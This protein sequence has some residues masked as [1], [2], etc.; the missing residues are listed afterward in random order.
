MHFLSIL[1]PG[2]FSW[3]YTIFANF[4]HFG[5]GILL[6]F[7]YLNKILINP[8]LSG[9]KGFWFGLLLAYTGEIFF[10]SNFLKNTGS[11]RFIFESTGPLI[12]TLGFSIMM[13]SSLRH[14]SINK[15]LACRPFVFIGRI[16]FSFYLWHILSIEFSFYY[17]KQFISYSRIGVLILSLL[18]LIFII[19]ISYI[20]F[21]IFESFYF[22]SN[23]SKQN[24]L[25]VSQINN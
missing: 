10:Y 16:S 6:G 2:D 3:Y 9:W 11:L 4:E 18:C 8:F 21:N 14:R 20:S 12:M 22:K 24:I 5:W 23:S 19:P 15:I 25:K 13:L 17:F 7:I 1:Y